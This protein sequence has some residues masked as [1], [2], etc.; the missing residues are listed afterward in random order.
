MRVR[1]DISAVL[2]LLALTGCA[3]G[4]ESIVSIGGSVDARFEADGIVARNGTSR[5][6]YYAAFDREA[7]A[8]LLW[9]PCTDPATCARIGS[10]QAALIPFDE[11]GVWRPEESREA[12]FFWW[13]LVA[14]SEGGYEPDEIRSIV[15]TG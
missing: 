15:L 1:R 3:S 2:L 6:I 12:V 5:T 14:D 8:L 9:A 11:V 4:C 7:L 10:G 13:H